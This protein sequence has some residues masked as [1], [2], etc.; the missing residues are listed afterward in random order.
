MN[1]TFLKG[2]GLEQEAID[3]I[4]VLLCQVLFLIILIIFKF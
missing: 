3:S 4:R 1:R 2:L